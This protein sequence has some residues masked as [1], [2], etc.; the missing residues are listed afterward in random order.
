MY[1]AV[2]RKVDLLSRSSSDGRSRGLEVAQR[3][4]YA[5]GPGEQELPVDGRA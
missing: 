1:N 3:E 2:E 4:R 5:V